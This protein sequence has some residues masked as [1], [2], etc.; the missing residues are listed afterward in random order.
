MVPPVFGGQCPGCALAGAESPMRWNAECF[1]ECPVCHVQAQVLHGAVAIWHR[2]GHGAFTPP[3]SLDPREI[4]SPVPI[5]EHNGNW[6]RGAGPMIKTSEH[7][8]R[9]LTGVRSGSLPEM[10]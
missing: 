6:P 4:S 1:L 2:L 5:Y 10:R 7:L 9:Y 3:A 8:A